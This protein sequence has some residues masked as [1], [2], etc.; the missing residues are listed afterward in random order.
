[1]IL[2]YYRD[3]KASKGKSE[4]EFNV[5]QEENVKNIASIEKYKT[6]LD[7]AKEVRVISLFYIRSVLTDTFYYYQF[8]K[9]LDEKLQEAQ[10]NQGNV[11][12]RSLSNLFID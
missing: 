10:A 9:V 6:K 8:I 5:L 3:L 12:S 4:A 11:S 2:Y 7:K 1:M